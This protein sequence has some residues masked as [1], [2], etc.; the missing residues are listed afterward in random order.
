MPTA[1]ETFVN[2]ELP[3]R[4]ASTEA[5]PTAGNYPR[6]TGTA[7]LTTQRTPTQVL[8][9]IAAAAASHTHS[10]TVLTDIGT[11]TH[12]QID[13]HIVNMSN[14]H[15]VT[16]AQ[17]GA[18]T[19]THAAQH[20]NGTDDV[21]SATA[22]VKGLMTAAYAAKLDGIEASAVALPVVDT[23]ALAKDPADG[24]RKA[25]LDV[26]AVATATTRTIT[27]PNQD[28][29]L[30]PN[31]GTFPAA[32][33]AARHTNGSDDVQ[34]ATTSVKG[35]MTAAQATTL[36]TAI[37]DGDYSANGLQ[38]RTAAGTYTSR[39]VAAGTGG[40]TVSNGDGVAGNPTINVPKRTFPF[41]WQIEDPVAGD[42]NLY[43]SFRCPF[44]CTIK[45]IEHQVSGGTSVIWNIGLRT[46]PF[47][48]TSA[49]K[50][51]TADQEATTAAATIAAG[52][53][54]NPNFAAGDVAVLQ[55]GTVTGAVD[56]L[57][58]GG[59]LEET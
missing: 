45:E 20:T 57:F 39:S 2:D 7:K 8:S 54:N 16:A 47:G 15:A 14:P 32:A 49:T 24:T 25:R 13:I 50:V 33:H 6:Y 37:L 40:V 9:D 35:L 21:Q 4:L 3:N 52:S 44:A 19:A 18:A 27:M 23:T 55:I 51:M 12:A 26:G 43:I 38:T 36:S 34:D 46:T 53:I 42:H 5:A 28:V 22:S 30:T 59:Y 1:F 31:T 29:D 56:W 41:H 58:V 17:A 11:N 48:T 10:H